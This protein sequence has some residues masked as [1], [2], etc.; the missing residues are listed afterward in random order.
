MPRDSIKKL[1]FHFGTFS[2]L[3]N[4]LCCSRPILGA[5]F[6]RAQN[7]LMLWITR[8]LIESQQFLKLSGY[9]VPCGAF[10]DGHAIILLAPA[11]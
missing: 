3:V 2:P 11:R 8:S 9:A 7:V 5:A 4:A 10:S 1:K 6:L